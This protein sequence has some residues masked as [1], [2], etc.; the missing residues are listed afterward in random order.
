MMLGRTKPNASLVGVIFEMWAIT[1]R[2]SQNIE[3]AKS[4]LAIPTEVEG[5]NKA[6][7]PRQEWE[8]LDSGGISQWSD[9]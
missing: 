4:E 8:P 7:K 2:Y 3:K 6:W 5:G 9:L 1:A